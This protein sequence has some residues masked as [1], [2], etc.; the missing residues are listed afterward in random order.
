MEFRNTPISQMVNAMD[1]MSLVPEAKETKVPEQPPL[2]REEIMFS[3]QRRWYDGW[4]RAEFQGSKRKMWVWV[5]ECSTSDED[6]QNMGIFQLEKDARNIYSENIARLT[7]LANGKLGEENTINQKYGCAGM[8]TYFP[9][10]GM[11]RMAK[12][13]ICMQDC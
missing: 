3:K 2:S 9:E 4:R 5:V 8:E 12:R 7:N 6:N 11:V 1:N 13:G 10:V